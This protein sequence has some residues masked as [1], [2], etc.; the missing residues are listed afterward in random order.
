MEQ[1]HQRT[2]QW[3]KR[4]TYN[5]WKHWSTWNIS[6]QGKVFITHI[7]CA[8]F[9]ENLPLTD[10]ISDSREWNLFLTIKNLKKDSSNTI[11]LSFD[12][13][14]IMLILQS[15]K[16]FININIWSKF[17]NCISWPQELHD[18]FAE[19]AK[20]TNQ[21]RLLLTAAVAAIKS[22][23]DASYEVPALAK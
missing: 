16:D 23:T 18:L 2:V 14:T 5:I 17:A 10:E 11:E 19:E 13:L 6:L 3:Q 12:I 7:Q 1:I 9:W 20:K 22:I 8:S 15:F 21:T 4:E